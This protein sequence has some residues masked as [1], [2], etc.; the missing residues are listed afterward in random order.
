MYRGSSKVRR[1]LSDGRSVG[2]GEVRAKIRLVQRNR[3][4]VS[5]INKTSFS[6]TGETRRPRLTKGEVDVCGFNYERRE[7][8]KE[9]QGRGRKGGRKR[10][11]R[12]KQR[13]DV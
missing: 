13:K 4:R 6:T 11:V 12:E 10:G 1:S 9:E 5:L 2:V 3:S 7:G 8:R